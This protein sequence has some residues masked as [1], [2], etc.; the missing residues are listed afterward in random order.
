MEIVDLTADLLAPAAALLAADARALGERVRALPAACGD[1]ANIAGLQA[2]VLKPG[3][4]LAAVDGDSLLGFLGWQLVDDFR[5]T[6]RR[7][8]Y[9]PV[10]A[11]HLA[12]TS[13]QALYSAASERWAAAGCEVHALTCVAGRA[14]LERLWFER[15]FGALVADALRST[16]PLD[17][18]RVEGVELRAARPDDASAL[19]A[20]DVEH[21]AHYTA[22]PALMAPR[23]AD[24]AE[25]FVRLLHDDSDAVWVAEG[26]DGLASFLRFDPAARDVCVLSRAPGTIGINGAFTRHSWRGRGVAAA[27]LAAATENFRERGVA[28]VAVDYELINPPA[29]AFWP[30]WFDVVAMSVM[31]IPELRRR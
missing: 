30:R 4:A 7:A 5:G 10:H 23:P 21:C 31:R 12:A 11:N 20:L 22:P 26:P 2:G 27:L 24:T 19:A 29:A 3:S 15:G 25:E 9:S 14:D 13:H 18:P 16:E 8:A 1:P 17:V 6:G 28:R